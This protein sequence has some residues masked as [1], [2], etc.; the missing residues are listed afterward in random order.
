MTL[1]S[2][3]DHHALLNDPSIPVTGPDSRTHY[4]IPYRLGMPPPPYRRDPGL[5]RYPQGIAPQQFTPGHPLPMALVNGTPVAMAHQIK[6][7]QPPTAAPQMRIS[8]NGGM[9]PPSIPATGMPTNGIQINGIKNN[10]LQPNGLQANGLQPNGLPQS[11]GLQANGL[12]ANGI[13][14]N[15][16]TPH[17]LSPHPMP[18]PVPQH[19]PPNGVNG[20][21][22]AAISMPHIDVQKPE[23][24]PTQ[25]ISTSVTPIPT[26]D[27]NAEMT[28]NGLP[29]RPKSQNV[30]PQSHLALGVP[31]NGYHLTPMTN[32]AALVNS[33]SYQ[34]SQN[35]SHASAGGVSQQQLQ[36]LKSIFLPVTD[37]NGIQA[38]GLS[39]GYL[40]V[41]PNGANLNMQLPPGTALKMPPARPMQWMNSPMQRPA[42]VVN[43]I[44]GQHNA[45]HVSSPNVGH[46][47]PVRSPSANGARPVMRNGV[48]VN[49]QH[50]MSPH[51]PHSP[52]PL[53]N[54]AQ[55]QSP[56]RVPMTPNMS[57]ASPSLQ[58]Q[59][60]VGGTQNGY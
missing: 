53:P 25:A 38:R 12:P 41:G 33:A 23:A 52:S 24:L 51:M 32:M 2:E 13:Q 19:S 57:M 22:R 6:K 11:N 42:S 45:V 31:T 47:V 44:D 54:I 5:M 28:V 9:R 50:S 46:A 18:V 7:M 34:H 20:T 17:H 10:G 26:P 27:I 15:G 36:N 48:H 35:Q 58:Q 37:A 4:V 60:P 21:G 49:G 59:Q 39:N 3:T 55:S 8:S 29:V 56:P 16:N 1:Y 14:A 40:H 43:G 30:T